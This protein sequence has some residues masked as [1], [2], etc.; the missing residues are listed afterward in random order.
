ML[1]WEK[2]G[3][4][5]NP[6]TQVELVAVKSESM[7]LVG[8]PDD[9]LIGRESRQAPTKIAAKKLNAM[10][11]VVENRIPRFF[12]PNI[13]SYAS[14]IYNINLNNPT[15]LYYKKNNNAIA[16]PIKYLQFL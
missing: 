13:F 7:K 1:Q 6:V 3:T 14:K 8:S 10:I 4:T 12:I 15:P 5:T 16:K 11:S 2:V 9:E